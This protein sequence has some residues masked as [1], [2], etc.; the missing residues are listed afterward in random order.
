MAVS[1]LIPTAISL[2]D[3][4]FPMLAT[5][6]GGE[7]AGEVADQVVDVATRVAGLPKDASAKE[8]IASLGDDPEAME[9]VR[10]EFAMLD[11]QEHARILEDRA[12]ARNYQMAVGAEGR[13]R[14]N[15]MLICVAA[16]L[17]ACII[18]AIR[19]AR[20]GNEGEYTTAMIALIT[21]VAGALLKMLSDA[22]AFEFGSSRGSKEK[23]DQLSAFRD[24][25]V[26]VGR[27]NRKTAAGLLENKQAQAM[28]AQPLMMQPVVT[29]NTEGVTSGV[30]Q[31]PGVSATKPE[32]RDFVAELVA[33]RV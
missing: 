28:A 16:G 17:A 3:A 14:G 6:L 5:K 33:G 24:A 21:T 25:L 4:F 15:I 20:V 19:I 26:D 27:E 1:F 10:F 31:T 32:R 11:Q 13:R 18:A 9:Q 7:R 8:I 12:S 23:D 22:F 30:S 29:Q 2:A